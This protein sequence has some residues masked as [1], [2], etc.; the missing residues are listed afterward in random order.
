MIHKITLNSE[1]KLKNMSL[2]KK[3]LLYNEQ[4][5]YCI[6][7]LMTPPPPPPPKKKKKKQLRITD[8]GNALQD[9][10]IVLQ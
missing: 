4:F 1:K 7:D 6:G 10:W 3:L 8:L 9:Q 5:W 2:T